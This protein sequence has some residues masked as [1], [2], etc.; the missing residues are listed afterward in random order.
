MSRTTKKY[1]P[2]LMKSKTIREGGFS[3]RPQGLDIEQDPGNLRGED[4]RRM[5][6]SAVG[7]SGQKG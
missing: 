2:S 3:I 1:S 7:M 4:Y 6:S 5:S